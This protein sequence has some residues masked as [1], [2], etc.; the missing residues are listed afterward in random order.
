MGDG[1]YSNSSA[2]G[3]SWPWGHPG[4]LP[5]AHPA[6]QGGASGMLDRHLDA[7]PERSTWLADGLGWSV[8]LLIHDEPATAAVR[9]VDCLVPECTQPATNG[10]EVHG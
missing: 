10:C 6:D 8:D 4:H 3:S 9:V 1:P 7:A 5:E 2:A